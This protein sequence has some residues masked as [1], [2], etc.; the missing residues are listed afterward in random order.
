M[1]SR[2]LSMIIEKA[3]NLVAKL[4]SRNRPE[5]NVIGYYLDFVVANIKNKYV[6]IGTCVRWIVD[7]LNDTHKKFVYP[8]VPVF[9]ARVV[10]H[11][12][13]DI[14]PTKVIKRF[15]GV[16]ADLIANNI[17]FENIEIERLDYCTIRLA[18][19]L[20]RIPNL[21]NRIIEDLAGLIVDT[22]ISRMFKNTDEDTLS[23]ARRMLIG[24]AVSNDPLGRKIINKLSDRF[25]D[26]DLQVF[27][28]EV[29]REIEKVNKRLVPGGNE[30]E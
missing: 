23:M 29:K 11:E 5:Y 8:E 18:S 28:E 30:D 17:D 22:L 24:I 20:R 3:E 12:I 1:P 9:I 6:D 7:F 21:N 26:S 4:L 13:M 10:I 15:M 16:L 25:E 27:I 14:M 2:V 19:E